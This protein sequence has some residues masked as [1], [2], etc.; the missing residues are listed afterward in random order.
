MV[1][2]PGGQP[3][4]GSRL[5]LEA[6]ESSLV[7]DADAVEDENQQIVSDDGAANQLSLVRHDFLYYM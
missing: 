1:P 2:S 5:V 6:V 7:S 4:K 3:W